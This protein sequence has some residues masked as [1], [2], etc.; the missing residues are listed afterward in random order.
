MTGERVGPSIRAGMRRIAGLLLVALAA[1]SAPE[2][3]TRPRVFFDCS[4]PRCD[5][6]YYRTEIAWV[7]WVND[8]QDA[9]VHLIMTSQNT[10]A[11][12]REYLLDFAGAGDHADYVDQR[13]FR[14]LPTDTDRETLDGI[15]RALALGLAAF[16]EEAG[17]RGLV[18]LQPA[19]RVEEA[20][21]RGV[22]SGD[23]VEDPWNLWVFRI[24][25]EAGIEGESQSRRTNLEGGFSAS[26]VTPDW[27]IRFWG[28]VNHDR[29]SIDLTDGTF[30][31]HRTGWDLASRT[32]YALLDHWSAG[33]DLSASRNV[34]YNQDFRVEASPAIEYSVFPYEEA[35]RRSFTFYYTLGPAYRDYVERT[36]HG[37][38]SETRWEQAMDVRF[39][40]RQRW[41]NASVNLRGSHFL[42]D[43]G[44]R[45]VRLGSYLSVRVVRGIELSVSGNVSWVNDQIYLPAGAATD[46]EAL[47]QLQQRATDFDYGVEIG[48]EFQF[49]SIYNNVVNNRFGR[50]F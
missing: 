39:S 33:I 5:S 6:R 10:G 12:G 9:Q 22:V 40:Q 45:L 29:Y 25:T 49:G 35:T 2:A 11:G 21:E 37:E 36:I 7:H 38:T 32:V 15:A 34:N 26:R 1:A 46:V 23:E 41:G 27:R 8:R 31:D 28:D 4:G 13:R 30:E 47:L 16:A 18:T 3:Q 43:L 48:F 17:Y 24:E 42:H 50:R 14:S 44:Q 19:D 20:V